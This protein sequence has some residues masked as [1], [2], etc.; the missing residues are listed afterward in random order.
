MTRVSRPRRR[1]RPRALL[2][3]AAVVAVLAAGCATPQPLTPTVQGD[4][5]EVPLTSG[6]EILLPTG[7]VPEE[8]PAPDSC[9]ALASLRPAATPD[10][11]APGSSLAE[12]TARGRLIVGIDQN[13]NLFSFRDPTTGMLMGF[14][15]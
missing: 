7:D 3:S 15:V 14:D 2:L 4:Y 11:R 9:G 1:T 13:T 5:S 12:I 8:P 6:S 10:V